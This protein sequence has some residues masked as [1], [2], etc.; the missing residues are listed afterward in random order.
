MILAQ[1]D[2]VVK[3]SVEMP[4]RLQD[5]VLRGHFV[6]GMLAGAIIVL[7]VWAVFSHKRSNTGDGA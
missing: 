5:H 4:E 2:R 3:L 7:I 6:T 1:L